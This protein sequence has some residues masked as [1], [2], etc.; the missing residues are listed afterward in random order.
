MCL[1]MVNRNCT[2]SVD[3]N[4]R[5]VLHRLFFGSDVPELVVTEGELLRLA[6]TMV[7]RGRGWQWGQSVIEFG[8]IHCTTRKPLCESC[9]LSDLCTARATIWGALTSLPRAE[10]ATYKV[11]RFEPLLPR[12]DLGRAPRNVRREYPSSRVRY[13]TARGFWR[14]GPAL[15]LRPHGSLEKDGLVKI[16]AT[17]D[18]SWAVAAGRAVYGNERPEG[19]PYA[20]THLSLPCRLRLLACLRPRLEVER[21]RVNAVA[22]ARRLGAV[23]EEVALVSATHGAMYLRALHKEDAA[24]LFSL[25][26]TLVERLVETRPARARIELR[27]RAEER[28]SAAY[29]TVDALV[30]RIPVIARKGPLGALLPGRPVRLGSQFSTP[31]FFGLTNSLYH[32][33]ILAS[34]QNSLHRISISRSPV[35]L[36]PTP[37]EKYD[38]HND[39]V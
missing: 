17:E 20:T 15:T 32:R 19:T 23:V 33:A 29:A 22:L 21:C 36:P 8:V 39:G 2:A 35:C 38:P 12:T 7:P 18:R 31:F 24:V 14:R 26:V 4:A 10:K 30:L 13:N 37:H 9:S 25:D 28:C 16:S 1:W 3:T 27:L 6:K 11:R 5:R 34:A